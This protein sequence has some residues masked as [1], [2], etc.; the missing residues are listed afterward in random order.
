MEVYT[1]QQKI[2]ILQLSVRSTNCLKQQK[3]DYVGDLVTLSEFDLKRFPNMGVRSVNEIKEKLKKIELSLGMKPCYDT[4]NKVLSCAKKEPEINIWLDDIADIEFKQTKLNSFLSCAIDGLSVRNKNALNS[5]LI[6]HSSITEFLKYLF[7]LQSVLTLPNVGKTSESEIQIFLANI[8]KKVKSLYKSEKRV[9]STGLDLMEYMNISQYL[10][11]K[12]MENNPDNNIHFF[13]IVD[14]LIRDGLSKKELKILKYRK[15]YWNEE[16]ITL[17]NLG[18]KLGVT[19][20]RVRQIEAKADKKLWLII[21]RLSSDCTFINIVE[22]YD[23]YGN[24][25][26]DVAVIN[27][28]DKMHFSDNFLYKIL[29]IFLKNDYQL[30]INNKDKCKYLIKKSFANEFNF[31]GF[32]DEIKNLI[33]KA[34]I[35]YKLDFKGVLYRHTKTE[36]NDINT[37]EIE[38]ICEDLLNLEFD[39]VLDI[40]N[41]IPI[42][43]K[44][45]KSIDKIVEEILNVANQPMHLDDIYS[46]IKNNNSKF[47]GSK[48]Y[49]GSSFV[50]NNKFIFFDRNSTYGLKSWE[51]ELTQN[52][53]L[54][55]IIKP[56]KTNNNRSGV[57]VWLENGKI[58]VKGG[59][60]IDIVIEYLK[61]FKELRHIDDVFTEVEKWRETNKLK[62]ISNLK[63]NNRGNFIFKN[64]FVGL[65]NE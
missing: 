38:S 13:A 51:G 15:N 58:I 26:S 14:L 40:D 20:E 22:L 9:I 64:G 6:L 36:Y 53:S 31:M 29:A 34:N 61:Q 43:G 25:I 46:K 32:I 52:S 59:T 8:Y 12:Y 37:V 17:K 11:D 27:K 63:A 50:G 16:R 30:L 54:I 65:A 19:R 47:D 49:I 1:M 48:K 10:R 39:I 21:N 24:I 55:N 44:K 60:V 3:I 62:L 41:Q 18:D 33:Q 4:N 42:K 56:N 23:F 28:K 57:K 35:D 45:K 5:E 2:E 7:S